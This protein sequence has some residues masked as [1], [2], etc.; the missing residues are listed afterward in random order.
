MSSGSLRRRSLRP[1]SAIAWM[2]SSPRRRCG[3]AGR[4]P[5]PLLSLLRRGFPSGLSRL[6]RGWP[7]RNRRIEPRLTSS[8][9]STSVARSFWPAIGAGWRGGRWRRAAARRTAIR[10]ASTWRGWGDRSPVDGDPLADGDARDWAVR[11]YKRHLKAVERW[12]PASV[13]LSLAALDSFY[14][15]LGLGGAG[16]PPRG[17]CRPRRFRH[18]R[19]YVRLD[20]ILRLRWLAVLGQIV[21]VFIVL[22]GLDFDFAVFPCIAIVGLSPRSIWCC[23]PSSIRCSGW[24][25]CVRRRCWR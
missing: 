20:T 12:K 14:T 5:L 6:M 4:G 9:L 15:E 11:D 25:R 2:R 13:N 22:Q 7:P 21:A 8:P 19:R 1:T 16:R 18:P 17:L 23:R 24:S 3:R 10:C